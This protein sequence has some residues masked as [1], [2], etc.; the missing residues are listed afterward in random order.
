MEKKTALTAL[1]ALGHEQRLDVFRHLVRAGREG[2]YAGEIADALGSR[3][4]TL[5]ANLTILAQ[6]GLVAS[7]REGRNI[8]YHAEMSAMQGLVAYLLEDCCGGNPAL[9]APV[10]DQLKVC[11]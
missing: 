11:C 9:C 3:P 2:A 8:R 4:N 5:S 7:V 6:A 10:F 1:S